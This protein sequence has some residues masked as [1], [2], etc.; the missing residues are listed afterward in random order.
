M[1]DPLL[2][3]K[4]GYN[5]YPFNTDLS[6]AQNNIKYTG[7]GKNHLNSYLVAVNLITLEEDQIIYGEIIRDL[8]EEELQ[9]KYSDRYP[10]E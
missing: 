10:T 6:N 4:V 7:M 9:D 3:L 1:L 8:T 2:F 5:N